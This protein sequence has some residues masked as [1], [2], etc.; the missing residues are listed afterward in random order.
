MSQEPTTSKEQP[1]RTTETSENDSGNPDDS[2]NR[3]HLVG[4]DLSLSDEEAR[5]AILDSLKDSPR[6]WLVCVAAC[7]IQII[8]I[9][10]LHVYGLFFIEFVEEFSCDKAKAGK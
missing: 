5:K 2:G 4:V 9:G 7:L 6:A 3:N 1:C 10:V 8:H